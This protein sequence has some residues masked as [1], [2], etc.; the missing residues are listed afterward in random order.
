M[1][2][3][4]VRRSSLVSC[5]GSCF[6]GKRKISKLAKEGIPGKKGHGE[7]L[8]AE[9]LLEGQKCCAMVMLVSLGEL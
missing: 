4:F 9:S 1:T 8:P 6:D 2:Y 7:E 3:R 5:A